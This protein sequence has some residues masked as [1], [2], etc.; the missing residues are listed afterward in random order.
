MRSPEVKVTKSAPRVLC[1]DT[2][3]LFVWVMSYCLT[4]PNGGD[5]NTSHLSRLIIPWLCQEPRWAVLLSHV[6]LAE[7]AHVSRIHWKLHGVWDSQ[8]GLTPPSHS[9]AASGVSLSPGVSTCFLRVWKPERKRGDWRLPGLVNLKL[10]KCQIRS[11]SRFEERDSS[12]PIGARER[13]LEAIFK[14]NL[15]LYRSSQRC[16]Q[17]TFV[18]SCR[19]PHPRVKVRREGSSLSVNEGTT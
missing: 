14:D 7:V 6:V 11:S 16:L 17:N 8:K 2:W 18:E 3:M 13:L 1:S 19:R 15:P 10:A 5:E 9:G 12:M 4:A